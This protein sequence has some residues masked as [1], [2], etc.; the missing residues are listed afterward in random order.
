MPRPK[1]T[2]ASPSFMVQWH[3]LT[4]E[5]EIKLL[6]ILGYENQSRD[7]FHNDPATGNQVSHNRSYNR[8]KSFPISRH[9]SAMDILGND[10]FPWHQAC[11]QAILR[12][13]RVPGLF[14]SETAVIGGSMAQRT[15]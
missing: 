3:K 5:S 6:A 10:L 15:F 9:S 2:C 12:R 13:T 1:L 8:L 14:R 4:A 7:R 11:G